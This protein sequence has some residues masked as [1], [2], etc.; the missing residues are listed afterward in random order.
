MKGYFDAK[1][2]NPKITIE[3]KGTRRSHN[4]QVTALF[5]TGHSG[6][7]SLPILDLIE[8]GA[9]LSNIG[10]AIL[11]DGY[12]KPQLYFSV[13]VIIDGIEK[14]VEAA[15]IEN[16]EAREAIV[17]L[18]LFSPYIAVV[19]F[20]NKKLDFLTEEDLKKT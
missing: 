5:D 12:K 6:S 7:L 1:D 11:A 17:G 2:G 3:I 16:P 15:L 9:K 13:K 8:I 10:E 4:K 20:K 18:E 19:D 14:D